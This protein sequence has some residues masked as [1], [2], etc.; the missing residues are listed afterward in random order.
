[1]TTEYIYMFSINLRRKQIISVY[2][3]NWLVCI[4]ETECLYRAVGAESLN[5]IRDNFRLQ[6]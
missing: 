4:T 3:I 6:V 5:K 1:M 2:S